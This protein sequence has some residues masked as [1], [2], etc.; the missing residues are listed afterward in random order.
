MREGSTV[1]R[2]RS[3]GAINVVAWKYDNWPIFSV[4]RGGTKRLPDEP[5]LIVVRKRER[6]R[7]E[8]EEASLGIRREPRVSRPS[9]L[10]S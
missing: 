8:I 3:R 1:G 5:E 9:Q 4:L 7:G 2:T 10:A 6:R